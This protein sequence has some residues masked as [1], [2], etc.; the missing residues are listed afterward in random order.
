MADIGPFRCRQGVHVCNAVVG[1][2]PLNLALQNLA[3]RNSK[4]FSIVWCG[5]YFDMLNR[6]AVTHE[7]DEQRDRQTA[8]MLRFTTLCGQK[9]T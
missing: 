9:T 8:S 1:G 2:E 4:H 5:K 7:C 6:L 3:L